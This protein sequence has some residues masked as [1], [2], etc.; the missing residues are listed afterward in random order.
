MI[1]LHRYYMK[2]GVNPLI[3]WLT[4]HCVTVHLCNAHFQKKNKKFVSVNQLNMKKKVTSN[5]QTKN[6][7]DCSGIVLYKSNKFF[8]HRPLVWQLEF[9]KHLTIL[10]HKNVSSVLSKSM[11]GKHCSIL[12]SDLLM[13]VDHANNFLLFHSLLS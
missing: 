6:E 12:L 5:C 2:T 10:E 8:L 13:R 9:M 11:M 4:I 7:A 1:H 3:I